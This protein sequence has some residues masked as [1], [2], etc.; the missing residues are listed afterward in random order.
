[1]LRVLLP[2]LSILVALASLLTWRPAPPWVSLWKVAIA[3]GEFGHVLVF[4]PLGLAVLCWINLDGPLRGLGLAGCVV[5]MVFLALPV[6]QALRLAQR[7]PGEM[8]AAFGPTRSLSAP[9]FALTRLYWHPSPPR[10]PVTTEIFARRDGDEMKLDF[11]RAAAPREELTPCLVVVHGGGWD[12]GDR[13]QL[14]EWHHRWAARGYAVAAVSYRLAP[15]H[16]WPAQRDDVLAA[17][18]WL[19]EN[20]LRL[21]LDAS[22]LVLVGRSAG[23]QIATA[24]AYGARDPAVVGVVSFYAP[25]DMQF[26]WGVSREDDALNSVNLMRQYLGGPPDTPERRALYDSA[27]AQLMI[28]A[29]TPPTLLIHGVPDALVWHRH[30]QRLTARLAEAGV[31]HYFLSLPWATHGFD[32]HLDGPGGQLADFAVETFLRATT[33]VR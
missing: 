11:Y 27:S 7:L 21:G 28:D 24:V 33:R 16:R 12:G 9:A 15:R 26:A 30:S 29:R 8:Q 19:K 13:S 31:R 32:Y 1:M 17:I 18:A 20:A 6:Q 3:V 22:R 23:G 14:A 2:A 25:Q 5:A 4:L 10:A